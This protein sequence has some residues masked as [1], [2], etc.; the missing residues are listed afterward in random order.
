MGITKTD[1]RIEK[2]IGRSYLNW[3]L[4]KNYLYKLKTQRTQITLG[5]TAHQCVDVMAY[6]YTDIL[7]IQLKLL[8]L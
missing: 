5:Q 2:Q 1:V 3:R 4:K 8:Y 6:S 7:L